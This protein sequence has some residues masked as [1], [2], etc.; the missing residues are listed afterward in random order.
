[1]PYLRHG[2]DR[3]SATPSTVHDGQPY[4]RTGC[5]LSTSGKTEAGWRKALSLV[6][7]RS[8]PQFLDVLGVLR[9]LREHQRSGCCVSEVVV[10]A[11]RVVDRLAPPA[12]RAALKAHELRDEPRMGEQLAAP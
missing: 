8:Q 12:R 7:E 9:P 2:G 4:R 10:G 3:L 6:P 11:R 1:M 5:Q